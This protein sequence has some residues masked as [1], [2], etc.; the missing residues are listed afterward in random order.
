MGVHDK[1]T[2]W[3]GGSDSTVECTGGDVLLEGWGGCSSGKYGSREEQREE[4]AEC[5]LSHPVILN[6]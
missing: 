1:T 2:L 4:S 5:E 3:S 6:H